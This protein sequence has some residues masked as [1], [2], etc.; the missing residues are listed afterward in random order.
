MIQAVL[1]AV[2]YIAA[3]YWLAR[4]TTDDPADRLRYV[5]H[6]LAELYVMVVGVVMMIEFA[7]YR[8][9]DD[10]SLGPTASLIVGT[11]EYAAL[12]GGVLA[13][14]GAILAFFAGNIMEEV[15]GRV[16][17]PRIALRTPLRLRES[18]AEE[19]EGGETAPVAQSPRRR[20][21]IVRVDN[22]KRRSRSLEV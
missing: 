21:S 19:E 2:A 10:V 11:F 15:R 4:M 7:L 9:P 13:F 8:T 20:D 1:G 6:Y 16:E 22:R 12:W 17:L 3:A 18:A 5:L 14:P